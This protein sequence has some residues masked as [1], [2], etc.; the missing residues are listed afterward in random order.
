MRNGGWEPIWKRYN[1]V[2]IDYQCEME[3]ASGG[4]EGKGEFW[5]VVESAFVALALAL[6][7]IEF[8]APSCIIQNI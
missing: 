4:G 7:L 3:E 6:A 5:T 2:Q 8:I 1:F